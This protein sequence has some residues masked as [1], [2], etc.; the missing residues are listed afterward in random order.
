MFAESGYSRVHEGR[1]IMRNKIID[2]T[3]KKELLDEV[4]CRAL[5][6]S[7]SGSQALDPGPIVEFLVLK[8]RKNKLVLGSRV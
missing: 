2:E 5:H 6:V 3:K 7:N 1:H 8:Q 4:K